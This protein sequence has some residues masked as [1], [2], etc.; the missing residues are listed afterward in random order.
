MVDQVIMP[1]DQIVA[2]ILE[3]RGKKVIIDA[4]LARLYGVTTKQLNQA[5][6]RNVERFPEDFMFTLTDAEKMELVTNCDQFV[7]LRHSTALPHAFTEHGALMA[8]TVLNTPKAIE[9]SVYVVR[10]FIELRAMLAAH[11]D[12]AVKLERI[13]R[14]LLAGLH[15]LE[16]HDD[17]LTDHENQLEYIIQTLRQVQQQKTQRQIGFRAGEGEAE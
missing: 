5:V 11:A 14:K 1:V 7:R 8:A 16:T 17:M 9:V 2:T 13:E 3:M 15:L 10:A 12:M 4:D 6:K